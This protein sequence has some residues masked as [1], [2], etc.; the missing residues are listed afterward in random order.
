MKGFYVI[1]LTAAIMGW[2]AA[3][4]RTGKVR[5]LGN[6]WLFPPVRALQAIFCIVLLMGTGFVVWAYR[7]PRTDRTVGISIG[8]LFMVFSAVTWPKALHL[9]VSGVHQR[10]WWGG[11]KRMS[12]PQVSE[13]KEQP[14]GSVV[15]RGNNVNIIFT[16]YHA[17][18]E[19]FLEMTRDN[20]LLI[21]ML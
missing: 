12:W 5:K 1:V 13:A 15:L 11:W 19:Q 10:S 3:Q 6:D 16:Q 18:R 20:G 4:A 2:L 14:D 9:S 21:R 17:G 7:G 8:L